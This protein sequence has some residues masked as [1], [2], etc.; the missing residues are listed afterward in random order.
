MYVILWRN[1]YIDLMLLLC[2]V[3]NN[4]SHR[5][6]WSGWIK[7]VVKETRMYTYG[8]SII[9]MQPY[10]TYNI[11]NLHPNINSMSTPIQSSII[12]NPRPLLL[13]KTTIIKIFTDLP[14]STTSIKSLPLEIGPTIFHTVLLYSTM[15]A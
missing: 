4:N 1:G 13:L 10:S 9:E 8:P 7:I 14:S 3:I 2:F 12:T 15:T 11:N 5:E 6:W